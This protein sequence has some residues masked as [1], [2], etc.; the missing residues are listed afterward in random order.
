MK[1]Q[2]LPLNQKLACTYNLTAFEGAISNATS[3]GNFGFYV[4]TFKQKFIPQ[5]LPK[6]LNV[7]KYVNDECYIKADQI[8]KN[9]Q[10]VY[11]NF[12]EKIL[13]VL[14]EGQSEW[15]KHEDPH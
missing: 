15:I 13:Y 1:K 3:D 10:N 12:A 14:N 7:P 2:I 9:L 5:P 8:S 4:D 11:Y 6:Y